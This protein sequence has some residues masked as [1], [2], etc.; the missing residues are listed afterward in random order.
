MVV[1][2]EFSIYTSIG[3]S[4]YS[5]SIVIMHGSAFLYWIGEPIEISFGLEYMTL[6]IDGVNRNKDYLLIDWTPYPDYDIRLG[7][8]LYLYN[9]PEGMTGTHTFVRRYYLTCATISENFTPVECHNP[10]ELIEYTP[11]TQ[12]LTVTFE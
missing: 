1:N 6:E 3:D 2:A 11:W 10:A 5:K 4:N 12:T 8:K 7:T 9:F